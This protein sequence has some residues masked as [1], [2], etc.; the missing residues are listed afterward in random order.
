MKKQLI[1]LITALAL[2][3]GSASLIGCGGGHDHEHHEE[4][5]TETKEVE[6]DEHG[7]HAHYA[8]PMD[9]EDGKVYDEAGQCPKCG[10]DLTQV[11]EEEAHTDEAEAHDHE[12]EFACP[13]HPEETGHEGD[14]CGKCG[15]ALEKVAE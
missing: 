4:P 6:H 3:F 10:M 5:S 14:K 13:M 8:C 7:E 12:H 11:S 15:M 9:C 2:I 1:G